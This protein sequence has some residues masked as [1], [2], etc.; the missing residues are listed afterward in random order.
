MQARGKP[1][2]VHQCHLLSLPT[3]EARPQRAVLKRQKMYI[4]MSILL[5]KCTDTDMT[6]AQIFISF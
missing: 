6:W 1:T 5:F 3:G 4:N 2:L